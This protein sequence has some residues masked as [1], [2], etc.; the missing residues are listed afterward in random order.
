VDY[1]FDFFKLFLQMPIKNKPV[2]QYKK[3]GVELHCLS[4]TALVSSS[5][6]HTSGK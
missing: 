5:L 3:D 1:P 4:F 2:Q 6:K